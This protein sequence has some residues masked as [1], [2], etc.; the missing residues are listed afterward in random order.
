MNPSRLSPEPK[1][2]M[3]PIDQIRVINPRFRDKRKFG[4]IVNSVHSVGLKKPITVSR[5]SVE[6]DGDADGYDLVC[7][8]GRM[9]AYQKLGHTVVPAIIIDVP[10]AERLLM[11]LLKTSP[12]GTSA[13][14]V[15]FA[16][17]PLSRSKVTALR[18]LRAKSACPNPT[19]PTYSNSWK[20][21]KSASS[22]PCSR[23]KCP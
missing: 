8:Q 12:A 1:I 21:A 23:A 13:V 17:W 19:L 6:H 11:S 15:R 3:V 10:L 18:R 2:E 7:G 16:T 4:Q 9:E 14:S 5:R 20:R 22:M